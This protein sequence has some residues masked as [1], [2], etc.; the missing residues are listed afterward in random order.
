[1][2]KYIIRIAILS[3]PQSTHP[4]FFGRNPI[5]SAVF[6][7]EFSIVLQKMGHR[8]HVTLVA[9]PWVGTTGRNFWEDMSCI[10]LFVVYLNSSHLLGDADDDDGDDEPGHMLV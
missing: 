6:A 10:S 3:Q 8:A 7:G 1:L 9:A 4:F 2:G 5:E